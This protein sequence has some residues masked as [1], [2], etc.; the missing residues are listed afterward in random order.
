MMKTLK[1]TIGI[2]A[3]V[4]MLAASATSVLGFNS[5]LTIDNIGDAY[6]TAGSPFPDAQAMDPES[7][8]TTVRYTLPFA[9][10][11]G[12]VLLEESSGGPVTDLLRFDGADHVYFFST[13][14]V[15]TP[16]YVSA[17]P[18]TGSPN[19]GPFV[20]QNLGAYLADLNYSPTSG[21][22][23]YNPGNSYELIVYVPEPSVML[24]GSLGGG[25]LLFLRSRRQAR[26]N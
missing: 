11:A 21:Q 18:A 23:G 1:R 5:I 24:L 25:L 3:C 16:S 15:G 10:T 19:Q 8:L 14:G 22:P 20:L 2:A 12:D 7:G 9:G 17:L 4:G 26:R 6:F 13:D